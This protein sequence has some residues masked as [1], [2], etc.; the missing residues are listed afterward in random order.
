[1][2]DAMKSSSVWACALV[3]AI[4]AFQTG[5]T[6]AQQL[7]QS[8]DWYRAWSVQDCLIHMRIDDNTW[9]G[10]QDS[11]KSDLAEDLSYDQAQYQLPAL[12]YASQVPA[13]SQT[14][15]D[16]S[17]DDAITK[18]SHMFDSTGSY[19]YFKDVPP[20]ISSQ[21]NGLKDGYKG[22]ANRAFTSNWVIPAQIEKDSL[23]DI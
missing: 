22:W 17:R 1:M 4:V 13:I 3:F 10:L 9:P 21:P 18:L 2:E 7:P 20:N 15:R 11:M 5:T 14:R 6:F 12:L 19:K 16:R 23:Y 8:R